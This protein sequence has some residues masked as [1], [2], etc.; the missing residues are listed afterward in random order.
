MQCD[1]HFIGNIIN[2]NKAVDYVCI[3]TF[4][5]TYA[6]HRMLTYSHKHT[7]T[8]KYMKWAKL[9]EEMIGSIFHELMFDK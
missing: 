1:L 9:V 7:H 4:I 5:Y 2:L 3:H 8:H 6:N